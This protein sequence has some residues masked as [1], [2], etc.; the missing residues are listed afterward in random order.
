MSRMAGLDSLLR[1]MADAASLMLDSAERDAVCGDLTE[2]GESGAQALRGVLSL[3]VRRRAACLRGW[4][5]W[6]TLAGLTLPLSVL[7]SLASRRTADSTAIYLWLYINNWD[8]TIIHNPGFWRELA[9]CAPGVLLSYLALA[10]WSWT[11]GLLVGCFARRFLWFSSVVFFVII[12]TVGIFGV[13]RFF[14]PFLVLQRARDYRNNAAVFLEA[15]YRQVFP[16]CLQLLLVMLPA[17]RGML[18]GSR[19]DRFP[20][21]AQ[22]F[23]L[24][25]SAAAV[26]TL[27]SDNLVWWQ[28]RVWDIQPFRQPRLPSMM[29]LAIAGPT[30]YLLLLFLF[31][32]AAAVRITAKFRNP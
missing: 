6:L 28:M 14:E 26:G 13:P 12:L 32:R 18:H 15:F 10:C 1:R 16:Q 9:Q 2:S 3:V 29:P 5:P 7:V 17:W 21:T 24:I 23:L 4:Q 25:A 11:T 30:A 27:V 22:L 20:R 31:G 8:W 19:T